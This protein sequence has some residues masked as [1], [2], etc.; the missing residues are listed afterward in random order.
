MAPR[1]VPTYRA[2]R[3]DPA[4]GDRAL[5]AMPPTCK[6]AGALAT[7]NGWVARGTPSERASTRTRGKRA[8]HHHRTTLNQWV[9]VQVRSLPRAQR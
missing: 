7:A 4:G 8:Q 2:V 9:P 6:D 1:L 3:Q 5:Q